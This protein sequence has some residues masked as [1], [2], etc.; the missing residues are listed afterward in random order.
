MREVEARFPGGRGLRSSAVR[1]AETRKEYERMDKFDKGRAMLQLSIGGSIGM[2]PTGKA[3]LAWVWGPE[4]GSLYQ[5]SRGTW[6]AVLYCWTCIQLDVIRHGIFASAGVARGTAVK[7]PCKES[8]E[9]S[10]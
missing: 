3:R 4:Q 10:M 9:T 7:T 5:K 2:P 8:G 1:D 6:L